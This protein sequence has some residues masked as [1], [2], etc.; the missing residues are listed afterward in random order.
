MEIRVRQKGSIVILDLCGRIDVDA[1]NFVEVVGQ[2]IHDG[3]SDIL[4]NF[5]SVDF[6]D[7]MG[8][9]VIVIAYKEVINNNGRMKFTDIPAHLK[10]FFSVAGLDRDID[11]YATED[12][13]M[14]SF[15]ED[16]AIE[17]IK[18]MQL[19]R[20]FKRLH[21]DIKIELKAK[22]DRSAVCVKGDLLNLSAIGAYIFGC[23]QFKLGDEIILKLKL[24]PKLEEIELEARVVWL[25]DKQIQ[26][27]SYP[28]MGVEFYNISPSTQQKLLEFI[29]KN[30]S[31]MSTDN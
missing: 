23:G 30:L 1:A 18:K 11:I 24:P 9:S 21:I 16:K 22:Y 14:N 28:G 27:H 19:R 2:C 5:E 15:K 29:E 8:I 26:P 12:I 17:N 31:F 4:C 10:G 6:I 13:A 20:R 3:Y 25:S 7:Y